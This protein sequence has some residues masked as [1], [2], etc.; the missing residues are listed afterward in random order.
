MT[1]ILVVKTTSLGDLVHT[2]PAITD[3]AQRIPDVRIDWVAEEAFTDIPTLHPA[4]R[5]VIPVALRR[6]R[7]TPW[8]S[9]TRHELGAFLRTLRAIEYDLVLDYQGLIKS[10]VITCLAYGR[11]WGLNWYSAREP[12]ATLCYDRRCMVACDQHAVTRNRALAAC[13]LGY[14]LP[15]DPPNYGIVQSLSQPI[16]MVLS[17]RYVV[18]LHA[19][20]RASKNWSPEHWITLGRILTKRG[21]TCLLPWGNERERGAAITLAGEIPQARVLPALTLRELASVLSGAEVV[22]GMDTGLTHL[23]VALG[24][25]TVALYTDTA[26]KLTGV[27]AGQI[28]WAI[29][30]GGPGQIPNPEQVVA[31]IDG[32]P[33]L[34]GEIS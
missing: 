1:N 3:L 30:L 29:N 27:L 17:E 34:L 5:R 21:W 23:A 22:I 4:I 18:C 15:I 24:R 8:Q 32:K 26:P 14:E 2:L 11:R 25:P 16:G 33:I 10:A 6:W 20:S 19:T 31:A 7:K 28:G 9:A 13:A 12:L